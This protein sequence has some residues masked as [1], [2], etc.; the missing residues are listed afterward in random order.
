MASGIWAVLWV[1]GGLI[2]VMSET[3]F[4]AMSENPLV[5]WRIYILGLLGFATVPPLVIFVIGWLLLWAL[6]GSRQDNE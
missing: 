1:G 3:P 2:A 6:V 4:A 5:G